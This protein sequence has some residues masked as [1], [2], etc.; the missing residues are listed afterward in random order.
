MTSTNYCDFNCEEEDEYGNYTDN[1]ETTLD[2]NNNDNIKSYYE[3]LSDKEENEEY[4]DFHDNLIIK[5]QN[6]QDIQQK[7]LN[8]KIDISNISTDIKK[9]NYKCNLCKKNFF[10]EKNQKLIRCSYC[11]YRILLKLRTQSHITYK[12]E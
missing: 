2:N 9:A 10:L 6:I 8:K 1:N 5:N 11:G 7:F 12:T 4:S 3:N